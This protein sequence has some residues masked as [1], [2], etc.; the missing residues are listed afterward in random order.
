MCH[1]FGRGISCSYCFLLE[2][3]SSIPEH[4]LC[5]VYVVTVWEGMV[6]NAMSCH[7]IPKR[8]ASS[9][10]RVPFPPHTLSQIMYA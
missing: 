6:Q 5:E 4:I 9:C 3:V 7:A 10:F 2:E 8:L 1:T